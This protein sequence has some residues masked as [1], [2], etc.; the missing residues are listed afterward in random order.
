MVTAKAVVL[1]I[2]AD[3]FDPTVG[4]TRHSPRATA[5]PRS[6][7]AIARESAAFAGPVYLFNG[8]SHVF[9]TDNPLAAGS[10]WLSLYG[11][12]APV[13]NLSRVTVDG[14]TGVNN[15][16]RVTVHEHGSPVLT[17]TRVPFAA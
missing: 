1:L 5:S 14:S 10:K 6:C 13:P 15:Y 17:W 8:D 16:L 9:N 4:R 3:M 2:Q 11:I 7:A 12:A